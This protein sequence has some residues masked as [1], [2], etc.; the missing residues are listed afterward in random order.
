MIETFTRYFFY[1]L[2]F[3][4][5]LTAVG[6]GVPSRNENATFKVEQTTSGSP[7]PV[8]T[9]TFTIIRDSYVNLKVFDPLGNEVLQLAKGNYKA[10]DYSIPIDAP[11]LR[12]GVYFYRLNVNDRTETKKLII[13]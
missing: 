11:N 4:L 13:K 6:Q 10:G 5:P 2:V 12:A 8:I 9:I 7:T 3:T 1:L